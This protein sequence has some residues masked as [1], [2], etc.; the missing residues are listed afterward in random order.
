MHAFPIEPN[1]LGLGG[2]LPELAACCCLLRS[3]LEREQPRARELICARD[4]SR[5]RGEASSESDRR[6]ADI[7]TSTSPA[8]RSHDVAKNKA[9]AEEKRKGM[10]AQGLGSG[11]EAATKAKAAKLY[12]AH[13]TAVEGTTIRRSNPR[14]TCHA[15]TPADVTRLIP[16]Y[17]V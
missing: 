3:S 7:M 16:T 2:H 10:K 13:L 11:A 14:L 1:F 4:L 12:V 17:N 6:S 5:P 8:A 9:L 15:A